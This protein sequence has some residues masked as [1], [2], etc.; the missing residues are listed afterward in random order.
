MPRC[1]FLYDLLV[2]FSPDAR[3]VVVVGRSTLTPSVIAA[4][5]CPGVTGFEGFRIADIDPVRFDNGPVVARKAQ[6]ALEG[7][8]SPLG[9]ILQPI[10]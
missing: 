10:P 9:L 8:V 1:L 7:P 6:E 4:P 5:L 3:K 2:C